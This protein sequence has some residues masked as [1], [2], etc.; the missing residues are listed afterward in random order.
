MWTLSRVWL[1]LGK[2]PRIAW[3]KRVLLMKAQ[4]SPALQ[5]K[6][7]RVRARS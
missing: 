1:T 2:V 5:G 7:S 4:M 6:G 3:E